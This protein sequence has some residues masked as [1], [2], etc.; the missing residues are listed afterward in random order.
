MNA[1]DAIVHHAEKCEE[2]LRLADFADSDPSLTGVANGLRKLAE[3][4]SQQA[5]HWVPLLTGATP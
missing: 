3:Y 2:A 4:H 5:F 1:H